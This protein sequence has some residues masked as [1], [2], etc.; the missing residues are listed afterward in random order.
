[1]EEGIQ[2]YSS[3][4]A[5]SIRTASKARTQSTND[6]RHFLLDT[7]GEA[8]SDTRPDLHPGFAHSSIL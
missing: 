4:A 8:K 2:I 6:L 7:F 5:A 3:N 1:M